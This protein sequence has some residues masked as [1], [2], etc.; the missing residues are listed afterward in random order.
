MAAVAACG[1]TN[2]Q[3]V[4]KKTS[5]VVIGRSDAGHSAS[6]EDLGV[7]NKERKALDY[8]ASGQQMTVLGE[9]EFMQLLTGTRAKDLVVSSPLGDSSDRPSAE[10]KPTPATTG[11]PAS[12]KPASRPAGDPG[13][14]VDQSGFEKLPEGPRW[15]V[16]LKRVFG[17]K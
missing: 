7:S 10:P 4:T 14:N 17:L 12:A 8:L 3:G 9:R 15:L 2:R 11:R 6:V 5:Y 16:I 1:A 13:L